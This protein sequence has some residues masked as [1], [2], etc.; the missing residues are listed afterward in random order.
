[1]SVDAARWTSREWSLRAV[2]SRTHA[3]T[4]AGFVAVSG[5]ALLIVSPR[6][7]IGDLSLVDDWSAYSK[8]PHALERLL[9]L[10]YDPAAVGDPHRYRPAWTAV[11]DNLVWHTLGAPGSL[12]GPNV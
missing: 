7:T 8:S 9:R 6:F 12:V 11:W 5:L 3:A 1:V 10:S 2:R 4:A